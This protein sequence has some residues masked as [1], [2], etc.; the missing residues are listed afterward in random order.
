MTKEMWPNHRV[1]VLSDALLFYAKKKSANLGKLLSDHMKRAVVVIKDSEEELINLLASLTAPVRREEVA[2]WADQ[3]AEWTG[4]LNK[5]VEHPSWTHGYVIY[6]KRYYE[7]RAKWEQESEP[8]KLQQLYAQM[9]KLERVLVDLEYKNGVTRRWTTSSEEYKIARDAASDR[10][11][12]AALI[13]L[14]AK[15]IERWFLLSLKAKYADGHALSKRL[16]KQV[17]QATKSVRTALDNFNRLDCSPGWLLARSLEFDQVKNLEADVWL[18]SELISSASSEVPISVKRRAIDLFHLLDRGKEELDLLQEEMKNTVEHF[19][20][21]HRTLTTLILD[22][23]ISSLS[24]EAKGKNV[25]FK[26]KLL[27]VEGQLLELHN[28]F[29]GCIEISIP[30]FVFDQESI[31][32]NSDR[33]GDEDIDA[34]DALL[35]LPESVDDA[36]F[37]ESE[38]ESDLGDELH[39]D[40]DSAFFSFSGT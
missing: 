36:L 6:L 16:S 8:E 21:Q 22:S 9:N 7:I 28:L 15:V 39:D 1:D 14:H 17:T 40:R 20:S 34:S 27:S 5:P 31:P 26:M 3:E 30:S 33:E 29:K 25:F 13:N 38:C 11:K 19:T 37:S 23:N 10:S 18:R 4:G 12:K 35:C 24:K 2:A 32:V